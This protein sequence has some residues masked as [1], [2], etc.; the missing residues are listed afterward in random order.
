[1]REDLKPHIYKELL[2]I[3]QLIDLTI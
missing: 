2:Q 1:M 3:R